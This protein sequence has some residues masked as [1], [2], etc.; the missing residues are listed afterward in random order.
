MT[1]EKRRFMLAELAQTRATLESLWAQRVEVAEALPG[2]D[3]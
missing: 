2:A 1:P 3:E